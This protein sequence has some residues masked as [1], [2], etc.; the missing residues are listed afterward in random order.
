MCYEYLGFQVQVQDATWR[1]TV[2]RDDQVK[3]SGNASRL[4]W[5][6]NEQDYMVMKTASGNLGK[7]DDEV[8]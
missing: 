6:M 2:R 4:A 5:C 1:S 8:E 7:D 3:R